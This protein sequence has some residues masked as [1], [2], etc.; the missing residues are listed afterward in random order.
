MLPQIAKR[1]GE[2]GLLLATPGHRSGP[3]SPGRE[4]PHQ[5]LARVIVVAG[6]GHAEHVGIG[7]CFER[8]RVQVLA[9]SLHRTGAAPDPAVL[10]RPPPRHLV[11]GTA[12]N[13]GA[14]D[15]AR[16]VEIAHPSEAGVLVAAQ[17]CA[18]REAVERDLEIELHRLEPLRIGGVEGRGHD[19]RRLT[20]PLIVS[21]PDPIGTIGASRHRSA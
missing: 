8:D 2:S 6:L 7:E 10:V 1:L 9:E 12:A 19:E 17:P 4:N 5:I 16:A 11:P 21:S 14:Y 20:V 18:F 15:G 3:M 13:L